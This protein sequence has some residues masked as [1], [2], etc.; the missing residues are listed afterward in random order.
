MKEL[1][2]LQKDVVKHLCK[3]LTTA[4]IAEILGISINT[5]QNIVSTILLKMGCKTRAEIAAK[6]VSLNIVNLSEIE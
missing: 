3:G 2:P 6:A 5:T 4:E 1:S